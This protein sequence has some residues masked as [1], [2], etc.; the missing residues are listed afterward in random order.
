MISSLISAAII[1]IA[2]LITFF[3]RRTSNGF[4]SRE[5]EISNKKTTRTSRLCSFLGFNENDS[6]DST[7]YSDL[8]LKQCHLNKDINCLLFNSNTNDRLISDEYSTNNSLFGT[9]DRLIVKNQNG[10][11]DCSSPSSSTT[12]SSPSSPVTK[13]SSSQSTLFSSAIDPT[14]MVSAS[15]SYFVNQQDDSHSTR[16]K[17]IFKFSFFVLFFL[18][19]CK[20][21]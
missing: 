20:L 21:I 13:I 12:C 11:V 4:W 3:K 5:N 19:A 17:F 15:A 7:I 10:I 16:V 8:E 9:I 6:I 18:F 2:V 14:K 1:I